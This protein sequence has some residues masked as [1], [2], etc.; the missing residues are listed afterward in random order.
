MNHFFKFMIGLL[1]VFSLTGCF[2]EDYDVGVPTAHLDL[3][4]VSVQLTEANIRWNTASEDVK[5]K[6]E[7]IEKFASSLDEIKVFSGQKVSLEF[8]ENEKNGGD[9][10]TDPTITV[11]LLKD[12]K[13]IELALD[14]SGEFQIPTSKGSYVLEVEFINSAGNAQYVGNILIQ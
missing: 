8:K 12:N 14:D 2:G 13:Q 6:I 11:A 5:Q 9:I 10:W 3:D 4:L 1:F 7:D